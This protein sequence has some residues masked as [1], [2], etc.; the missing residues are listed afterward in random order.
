VQ[1]DR[2]TGATEVVAPRN[3]S[4]I[5]YRGIEDSDN[6]PEA[7]PSW[8]GCVKTRVKA[9]TEY[10]ALK[11]GDSYPLSGGVW[12]VGMAPAFP[13]SVFPPIVYKGKAENV[14]SAVL[15]SSGNYDYLIPVEGGNCDKVVTYFDDDS[16][17]VHESVHTVRKSKTKPDLPVG[18]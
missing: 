17:E 6:I 5:A 12:V 10:L 3:P 8:P 2:A 13:S 1:E 4:E 9:K 16:W 7:A 11:R 18:G 14:P 15:R